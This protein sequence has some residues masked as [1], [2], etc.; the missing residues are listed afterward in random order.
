MYG[1]QPLFQR[2]RSSLDAASALLEA[3]SI[4]ED[5]FTRLKAKA[6]A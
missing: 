3:G 6:L 2:S 4:S 5:E 1:Y